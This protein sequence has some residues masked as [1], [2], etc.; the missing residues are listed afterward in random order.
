MNYLYK[1]VGT[2]PLNLLID[3]VNVEIQPGDWV[4]SSQEIRHGHLIN[5]DT[6]EPDPSADAYHS[7]LCGI[8]EH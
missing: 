3:G 1:Y 2:A 6:G 7:P 8:D 5:T 4:S